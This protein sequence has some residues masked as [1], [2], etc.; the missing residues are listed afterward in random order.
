MERETCL[1]LPLPYPLH[2]P[3]KLSFLSRRALS[4]IRT[5]S[6]SSQAIFVVFPFERFLRRSVYISIIFKS[7]IQSNVT[8]QWSDP[9]IWS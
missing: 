5:T 1:M 2:Q 9:S 6:W 7:N 8:G 3:L 4:P